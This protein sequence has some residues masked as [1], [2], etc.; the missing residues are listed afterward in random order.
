[1]G[2]NRG[3]RLGSSRIIVSALAH[4]P[5]RRIQMAS[6]AWSAGEASYLVG[7]FIYAY[8]QA[9]PSGVAWVAVLR[10]IP[11]V[12]LAPVV[13]A[14]AGRLP[15]DRLLRGILAVRVASVVATVILLVGQ[16]PELAIYGLVAIDAVAATL[17]R[18]LRGSMLPAIARSPEELVAGNVA[19]TTGDSLANLV[20]PSLAAGSLLLGG[21]EAPFVPGIALLVV[22]LLSAAGVEAAQPLTARSG[23][24]GS[25]RLA[26]HR[27]L[28]SI[29]PAA[30][31]IGAF[32]VQRFIRGALTV[33]LVA[34]AIDLLG[35]G[36][37]GVGLLT[38]AIGLGG[39]LGG[40]IAV[41]LIGR[42]RLAPWFLVGIGVWSLAIALVGAV[43]VP[44]AAM[45]FL[46]V[47]GVGKVLIDVAGSSVLQRSIPHESRTQ[48]LGIQEGLV[49]AALAIG[50][51]AASAVIDATGIGP[52]MILAGFVPL[53]VIAVAGPLLLRVDEHAVGHDPE[54]RLLEALPLFRPLQLAT[55]EELAAELEHVPVPAGT[56]IVRQ[57]EPG[58]RFFVV[59][60]GELEVEVDG[61]T[62]GP[63]HPGD[64]FG[65]IAL[66]RDVPRTATVRAV[67]DVELAALDRAP[68]LAA[69]TGH[70]ESAM[71]A[72]RL[73]VER[74]GG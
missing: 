27:H 44:A 65:E 54:L 20:G 14:I 46:T 17:L 61:R 69:V 19:L 56:E 13:T 2:G 37:A 16:A 8:D 9:G 43:P 73:V 10:T 29:G 40:G 74:L 15:T 35:M 64:A 31:V 38:A 49:T 70:R 18:P 1:M 26:V 51:V 4:P 33:L 36:N 63:L 55:K 52:A 21:A 41:G 53:L 58:D 62:S 25:D 5:M 30:A 57:G 6:A 67:T 11:S 23:G 39:L 32:T 42:Q 60:S 34:A 24:P 12:V 48:V 45:L 68:F 3:T 7:V 28:R 22:A 47:G 59:E 71:A 66:L 50:A 72:D